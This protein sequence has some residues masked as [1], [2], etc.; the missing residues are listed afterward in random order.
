VTDRTNAINGVYSYMSSAGWITTATGNTLWASKSLEN[1]ETI[2]SKINQTASTVTILASHIKLEGIVTAN[3]NFKVLLDGSIEAN[4][5][6]IK[7][8]FE[9]SVGNGVVRMNSDGFSLKGIGVNGVENNS[10]V[11]I[12]NQYKGSMPRIE[13]NNG[14]NNTTEI[15]QDGITTNGLN[16]TGKSSFNA[17]ILANGFIGKNFGWLDCSS[18]FNW[19][20]LANS[21][22]IFLYN[23]STNKTTSLPNKATLQNTLGITIGN[24]FASMYTF[25]MNGATGTVNFNNVQDNNNNLT[26]ITLANGDVLMLIA[27]C[28]GA[29]IIWQKA[30]L[31]T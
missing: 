25:Y 24:G 14:T 26:N 2:V 21:N 18:S 11:R 17:P 15:T 13:L 31:S 28:F 27:Y 20:V 8:N 4:N 23:T 12:Y 6:T 10:G 29:E 9:G 5:A 3:N 1:G 22:V 30:F 7:G 19:S 16:V